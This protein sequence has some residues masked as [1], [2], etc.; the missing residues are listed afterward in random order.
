MNC[1]I[2]MDAYMDHDVDAYMNDDMDAYV[3]IAG[4]LFMWA[5]ISKL[6]QMFFFG[7]LIIL[8]RSNISYSPLNLDHL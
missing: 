7:P 8:I 1:H 2:I 3:T 6:G 4:H 5:E